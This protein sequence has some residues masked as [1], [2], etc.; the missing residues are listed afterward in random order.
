MFCPKCGNQVGDVSFCPR[1]G[2]P[3]K[4]TID[5]QATTPQKHPSSDSIP[6]KNAPLQGTAQSIAA[7]TPKRRRLLAIIVAAVI[8]LALG[9]TVAFSVLNKPSIEGTWNFSAELAYSTEGFADATLEAHD[10][11]FTLTAVLTGDAGKLV[12]STQPGTTITVE[13]DY[14]LIS[15]G[16]EQLVYGFTLT[17][18]SF[19]MQN[20]S[21]VYSADTIQQ[22]IDQVNSAG[23]KLRLPPSGL[24]SS[25]PIGKWGLSFTQ[26]GTEGT[27]Y[28]DFSRNQSGDGGFID[29]SAEAEGQSQTLGT[30][31]T[32]SR[33][34]DGIRMTLSIGSTMMNVDIT[35]TR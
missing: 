24:G 18:I 32:W 17:D 7:K 14:N 23:V 26:S 3:I 12:G 10:S 25:F 5:S 31:D 16:D 29:Y 21:E 11:H 8:V 6:P 33:A 19:D 30:F 1:C 4:A 15:E 35:H 22:M 2:A 20:G 9:G 28:A 13:G 27:F 34:G